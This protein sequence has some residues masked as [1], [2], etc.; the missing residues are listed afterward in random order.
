LK[1]PLR[2]LALTALLTAPANLLAD[3]FTY[4]ASLPGSS[5]TESGTI[6]A[7]DLGNDV[8]QATSVTGQGVTGLLAAGVFQGNDNLLLPS[9]TASID[10]HGIAFMFVLCGNT[11]D[12]DVFSSS[13]NE[14]VFLKD[15][16]GNSGTFAL[17]IQLADQPTITPEPSSVLLV[18]TG[19][20][21]IFFLARRRSLPQRALA[22]RIAE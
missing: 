2:S 8:F 13:G 19:A 15:S 18:A 6:T 11:Y 10:A 22:R 17:T 5:Y 21:I 1:L 16:S 12:A 4:T 7:T 20:V 14:F 3:T 9:A